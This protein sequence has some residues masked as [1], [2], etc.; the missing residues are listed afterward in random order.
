MLKSWLLFKKKTREMVNKKDSV[1]NSRNFRI[2]NANFSG[3]CFYLNPN[4]S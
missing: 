1:N 2:K 4:M 3:N